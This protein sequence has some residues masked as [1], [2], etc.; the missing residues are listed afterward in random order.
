MLKDL[1]R[2]MKVLSLWMS[3][4]KALIVVDSMVEKNAIREARKSRI[5]IIALVDT[6]CDPDL[7]GLSN[8]CK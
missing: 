4:P 2:Y 6:N 7:V 3:S 1:T 5:P 8:T